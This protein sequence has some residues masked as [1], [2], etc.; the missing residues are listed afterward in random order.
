M[1]NII[2]KLVLFITV[3]A[4]VAGAAYAVTRFLLATDD[5]SGTDASTR[6][7]VHHEPVKRSY[8]KLDLGR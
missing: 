7:G 6:N 4:A 3:V 2:K 8:T 1:I 5:C